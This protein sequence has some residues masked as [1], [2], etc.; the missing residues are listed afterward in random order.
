MYDPIVITSSMIEATDDDDYD[1]EPDL[2][3]EQMSPTHPAPAADDDII[4]NHIKEQQEASHENSSNKILDQP[5]VVPD[6]VESLFP[7]NNKEET[8]YLT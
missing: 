2:H 7:T 5:N 6:P 3:M 1:D 4:D 8:R